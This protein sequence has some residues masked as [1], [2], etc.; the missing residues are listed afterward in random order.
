MKRVLRRCTALLF[1]LVMCTGLFPLDSA[2]SGLCQPEVPAAEQKKQSGEGLSQTG[3]IKM[4]YVNPLYEDGVSESDL[5]Q[6][7][8]SYS[9]ETAQISEYCTS[10]DVAGIQMRSSMK[11]REENI[12]IG[13]QTTRITQDMSE[14]EGKQ[15]LIDLAVEIFAKCVEHT[16]NPEEGD[17]LKW[18]Y[19]GW[20][21][22]GSYSLS[23]GSAY[24][25]F[26][27]TLT[28]YTTK[29]QENE[30]DAAVDNL[31]EQ[32]DLYDKNEYCKISRI[33]DY[34]CDNVIYDYDN[35]ENDEYK[36]KYTAYAALIN[37][38]AVCQGY[39]LLFY[40]LALEL[41]VDTRLIIGVSRGQSHAWNI[42]EINKKYYN[43][44]S[45]WDAGKT[46]YGCF[47]KC[48][49][50]FGDHERLDEYSS[51]EFNKAYPMDT[52]DYDPETGNPEI[53]EPPVLSKAE[54]VFG[55]V[56]ITWSSSAG[57]DCYQVYKKTSDSEKWSKVGNPV[58]KNSF[59][60]T[61]VE[62]GKTYVYT[63]SGIAGK[64]ESGVESAYDSTGI[65]VKYIAA[66]ELTKIENQN[67]AMK[68]TWKKVNGAQKYRL[69]VRNGKKW[70]KVGDTTA[71][72][73]VFKGI[74]GLKLKSGNSYQFTVRCISEDAKSHTSGYDGKGTALM[75]LS[76]PSVTVSN[77]S[78]GV[79]VKWTAITGAKGYYVYRK[80]GKDSYS[81][82]ATIK[83]GDTVSY[84]DT[85]V[86]SKNGTAYTYTVRA[87]NG[88]ARS[89]YT[90]KKTVRL[91]A[92]SGVS[93][94]NNKKGT[95]TVKWNKNNAASGYQ[96]RCKTGSD[97]KTVTVKGKSELSKVIQKLTKNKTYTVNVRCY[98]TVSKVN[99]YSGWSAAKKVKITK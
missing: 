93:V 19:A 14:D 21:C 74:S 79:T 81:R 31:L 61:D 37:K 50:N 29:A 34:I 88:S 6:S 36:L 82:I 2:A 43:L 51:D 62:S 39:A 92:P 22:S 84:T 58:E 87:Y 17:Y 5:D 4:V 25:T 10:V 42:A 72:S 71:T 70:V 30:M 24:V 9:I 53:M 38:K 85:S 56:N 15:E 60:D 69:Y 49:E 80:T 76:R 77:G 64:G 68:V 65:S 16:G 3:S 90:G 89:T 26:K 52:E 78:S 57:A 67:G 44:D 13:L 75:Y 7:F 95:I 1:V 45:T 23:E 41:D 32:L 73:A 63:V 11:E 12:E 99:Y 35:L 98:K 96:V 83:K 27:Y 18:Q 33:Y 97:V 55:G 54:S 59:K 91:T 94:S 20:K 46:E 28:Y 40:R 48:N 66:P 8:D 86:K 47:L